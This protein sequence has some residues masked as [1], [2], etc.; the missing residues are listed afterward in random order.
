MAILRDDNGRGINPNVASSQVPAN[1]AAVAATLSEFNTAAQSGKVGVNETAGNGYYAVLDELTQ[2]YQT[3][4]ATFVQGGYIAGYGQ[5]YGAKQLVPLVRS[6]FND[7]NG[8][9]AW[10]D[11]LAEKLPVW[12][13]AVKK[14][15]ANYH[16]TDAAAAAALKKTMESE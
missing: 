15:I 16:E 10:C 2:W 11:H 8:I 9:I 13:E 1:M 3:H 5:S 14:A 7:D 6:V 12:R 4:R